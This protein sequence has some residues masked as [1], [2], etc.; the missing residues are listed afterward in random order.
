MDSDAYAQHNKP[1]KGA[2]P[3][4][5]RH[6]DTDKTLEVSEFPAADALVRQGWVFDRPAPTAAEKQATANAVAAGQQTNDKK[7][8]K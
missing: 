1:E 5:Y 3:G 8:S 7:E 6:P 2:K 4:I